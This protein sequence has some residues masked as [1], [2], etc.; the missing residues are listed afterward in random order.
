[1][2]VR[3]GG[4]A[5]SRVA[6]LFA[7]STGGRRTL[8]RLRV[9]PLPA[10]VG[11]STRGQDLIY[12]L[13]SPRVVMVCFICDS[14]QVGAP[15]AFSYYPA[16]RTTH[17]G[18]RA[19]GAQQEQTTRVIFL[20]ACFWFSKRAQAAASSSSSSS[21]NKAP[22]RSIGPVD[23]EGARSSCLPP[24]GPPAPPAPPPLPTFLFPRRGAAA[25][26]CVLIC[27]VYKYIK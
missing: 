19:R 1:V 3:R 4:P 12:L 15:R 6:G 27:C 16:C 7:L 14:S 21:S 8:S 11:V 24:P 20:F 25:V 5:T 10:L 26:V 17:C 18:P 22:P 9:L 2:C 13:I 23:G